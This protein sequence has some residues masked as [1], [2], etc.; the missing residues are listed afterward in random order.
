[1][2]GLIWA[3]IATQVNTGV[4]SKRQEDALAVSEANVGIGKE[5]KDQGEQATKRADVAKEQR[6]HQINQL[7]DKLH[8]KAE[9]YDSIPLS[10][11][12]VDILCRAYRST[13]PVCSP[14]VKS[15]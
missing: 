14:T 9:S 7:K 12:D 5:A 2:A 11:S 6:T 8:E 1:M 13:D 3:F 4:T 15:D 10:P